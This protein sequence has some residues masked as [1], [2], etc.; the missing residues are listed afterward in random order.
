MT[1]SQ[2]AHPRA[3]RIALR[4]GAATALTTGLLVTGLGTAEAH[5]QVHPDNTTTGSFSALT[6]RVPNESA[7]AGT[8]KLSVQ[9]PQENPFIEVSARPL[10]GWTVAMTEAPLP[11]PVE[12]E[13]ATITKAVRTVTWTAAKGVQIPDGQYQEFAISVGPLPGPGTVLLPTIQTYSD[14]KTVSWNEPTP[15]SGEEPDRPAP[16]LTITAAQTEPASQSP[17]PTAPA[18]PTSAG[19]ESDSTARW[20]G[21]AALAVALVSVALAAVGL[22]R[23]RRGEVGAGP[24]A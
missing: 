12:L 9:L 7:T 2:L 14:G 5:V 20:L 19:P 22:G 11:K 10:P 1:A 17:S 18:T 6:F 8:V 13:G 16:V 4:V 21:G 15:A 3:T 23:S 24:S